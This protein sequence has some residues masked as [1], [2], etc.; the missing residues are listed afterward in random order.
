MSANVEMQGIRQRKGTKINSDQNPADISEPQKSITERT[1]KQK[2]A[3]YAHAREPKPYFI[4]RHRGMMGTISIIPLKNHHQPDNT[5]TE[6]C[7][8][9]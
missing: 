8:I 4:V 3:I 7:L 5:E 1:D 6:G 2:E 9:L